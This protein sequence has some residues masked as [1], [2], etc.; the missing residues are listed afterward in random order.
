M[1]GHA[2]DDGDRYLGRCVALEEE[3]GGLRASFRLDRSNPQAEAARAGELT[4]WSVSARVYRSRSVDRDGRRVVRREVAGIS[5]VAATPRP[6]YAGA[7]VAVAREHE[8]IVDASATPR[9][10]QLRAY[11]DGLPA[12]A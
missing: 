3:R 5:H 12:R 1:I 11:L 4:G 8:L 10:D 7:G 6:Q 2:G 9:R